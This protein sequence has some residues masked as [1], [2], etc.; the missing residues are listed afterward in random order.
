MF[1]FAPND[2]AARQTL[3]PWER[4]RTAKKIHEFGRHCHTC[5]FFSIFDPVL[6]APVAIKKKNYA[7]FHWLGPLSAHPVSSATAAS[8]RQGFGVLLPVSHAHL[9]GVPQDA[10]PPLLLAHDPPE[11]QVAELG[12][13]HHRLFPAEDAQH[14][15]G[16]LR[17]PKTH[18]KRH[19]KKK[20]SVR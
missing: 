10:N 9:N 2:G 3:N 6:S 7:G 8:R 5:L 11:G 19:S 4:N 12:V 13:D 16:R 20:K 15:R 1:R 14:Y 18:R 17:E